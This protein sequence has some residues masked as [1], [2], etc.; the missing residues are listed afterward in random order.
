MAK[1]WEIAMKKVGRPP[2]FES[3]EE[4]AQV[5]QEYFE[6]CDQNDIIVE[7]R[8]SNGDKGKQVTGAKIQRPYT[9]EG[10]AIFAGI[11]SYKQWR[12][13]NIERDGFRIVIDTYEGIIREKQI[14]GAV[15]GLFKE[16]IIARMCGF[17]ERQRV[18]GDGIQ[19]N[20]VKG[21]GVPARNRE[22]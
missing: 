18:E 11:G 13:D 14:S 12:K 17:E 7:N 19:V 21:E 2:K 22:E 1:L 8:L 15:V 10:F 4:L 3:A 6:W 16:N 9:L 20:I 5:A